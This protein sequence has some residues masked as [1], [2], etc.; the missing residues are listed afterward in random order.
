MKANVVSLAKRYAK[1]TGVSQ[2][3]AETQ[4]RA[5]VEVL[6]DAIVEDGG[7][8]FLGMMSVEVVERKGRNGVNPLNGKP[9][10]SPAHKTLKITTGSKLKD[11]LNQ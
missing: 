1:K 11:E 7:F 10:S 8:A 3:T 5:M 6:K 4:V 9:Y 2:T